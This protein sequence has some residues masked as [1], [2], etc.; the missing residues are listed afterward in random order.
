MAN[1]E[2]EVE[3]TPSEVDPATS[4]VAEEAPAARES[5]P[6]RHFILLP[7]EFDPSK[8][9]WD[10]HEKNNQVLQIPIRYDY[11]DEEI[12]PLKFQSPVMKAVRGIST[13]PGDKNK[14]KPSVSLQ[15]SGLHPVFADE[16]LD[17]ATN[18]K[19]TV[20]SSS[21]P[22][23]KDTLAFFKSLDTVDMIGR[24]HI[25]KNRVKITGKKD[26]T[27]LTIQ[28]KAFPVIKRADDGETPM[29]RADIAIY[30]GIVNTP[31]FAPPT[32]EKPVWTALDFHTIMT[33]GMQCSVAIT[34][35]HAWFG[36]LGFGIKIKTDA[37]LVSKFGTSF[38]PAYEANPIRDFRADFVS[39]V[40]SLPP[41]MKASVKQLDKPVVLLIDS[42]KKKATDEEEEDEEVEEE[43]EERPKKKSKVV[44]KKKVESDE[45][46]EE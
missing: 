29:F 27:A 6:K 17:M 25:V 3:T 37:V 32:Q 5:K 40:F 20:F 30:D 24:A 19:T 42:K 15:L 35:S 31:F 14:N 2:T 36:A 39:S 44:K 8:L 23:A 18:L 10:Q 9:I 12:H 43:E 1:P 22:E 7:H 41:D 34:V 4:P 38:K 26:I 45:E 33:V 13:F 46:E 21:N 11:G 16:K 28:T